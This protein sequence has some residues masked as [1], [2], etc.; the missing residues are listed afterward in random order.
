M[1]LCTAK[2]AEVEAKLLDAQQKGQP[3]YGL[4]RPRCD[5]DGSY[6]GMQYIGSQYVIIISRKYKLIT[7]Q[8]Y[9]I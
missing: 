6:A 8:I 1:G 4:E 2:L 5:A 3:L 7:K 9:S